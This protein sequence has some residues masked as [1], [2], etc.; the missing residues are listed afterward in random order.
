MS[1]LLA[2]P[3]AIPDADERERALDIARSFIVEAPAGSGKT[4]LLIQ[5]LLKLLASE[6]IADPG[7]I[8]AITFTRK[9]THE[10][11][12]RV[13]SQLRAAASG[14]EPA[15]PFD[16]ATRPLAEAALA[17][18]RQLGWDLLAHPNR[19][20]ISTIDALCAEIARSLPVLS[21]SGGQSP[22]EDASEL[23]QQ[24]ARQT[25]GL[26]GGD[27]RA[28]HRALEL[29]LLHRD[30]DLG[31]CEA[32]IAAMLQWRD[33]W[34]NLIPIA[35]EQLTDEYLETVTR[36][37]L[38]KA[39][40]QAICRALTRLDRLMPPALRHEL[41]DLARRMAQSEGYQGTESPIAL[42]RELHT[43]PGAAAHDLDH[44]RSLAHVAIAP[45]TGTFRK[46]AGITGR[47]LK[48]EIEKRHKAELVD[49]LPSLET[50]PGLRE[51]L[52]D[53]ANLPPLRY[54]DEQWVVA[55]ALFRVLSRALVE[56]QLVFAERGACDFTEFAILARS[57]LD[58]TCAVDD[59]TASIGFRLE[60]L[61][62]DEMQD[63]SNSQYE[64]IRLLTQ[65][66]DGSG[67]TV[68]LVGDPKQS[69]YLFRQAR[70]ER[71][72]TTL[73]TARLGDVPLTPLRLTANFRSQANLV[74]SFN[75]TFSAMF[76]PSNGRSIEYLPAHA[77][78]KRTVGPDLVWHTDPLPYAPE[79]K[80]ALRHDRNRRNSAHIADIVASWRSRPL[81]ANRAKPWRIAVLVRNHKHLIEVVKAFQQAAIPFRAVD[82]EPLAERPEILDLLAL[83]RALLNPADRTAWLALLR[84]PW[85][86]VTLRDLHLL[87][88]ADSPATAETPML[89]LIAE[90]GDLLSDDGV[91]RLQPFYTAM[92]AA[93]AERGRQPLA[94]WVL[95]T[96]E[97][98]GARA[99]ST[100]EELANVERFLTLL[101]ELASRPEPV[102]IARLQRRV[103]R[104]YA[105]EST[106]LNAVD[107][108]TMHKAKGLEWDVVLVPELEASSARSTGRLLS[109][110]EIESETGDPDAAR[111]IIA[112]V[113]ARGTDSQALNRWMRSID[114]AREAEERKRLFYVACTRAREEL[115]LFAAPARNAKGE[116]AAAS[117]SLLNAAWPAAQPLFEQFEEYDAEPGV[118]DLAAGLELVP[119]PPPRTVQRIPL[120]A[121]PPATTVGTPGLDS[122]TWDR[123]R[124][125]ILRTEGSFEARAFG[126]AVHTFLESLAERLAAGATAR[127]L[128]AELPTWTPRI[129]ALLRSGGLAPS[130]TTRG[131]VNVLRVLTR[132]LENPDGLW[133]L[134]PHE[135]AQSESSLATGT[136][137]IRIDRTFLAGPEPRTTGST[138]LWIVDFKTAAPTPTGL[139]EFLLEERVRHAPQLDT[140]ATHLA[141]RGLPI[142][143]ALYHPAVAALTWWPFAPTATSQPTS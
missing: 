49:L 141:Q 29:L 24:A 67:Q 26:L 57:A 115:H 97:A 22:V 16:A 75:E 91:E 10:M 74:H 124:Q 77:I 120:S 114:S 92:V 33:Q 21:G 109:W 35:G 128:V 143:L 65:H 23:Y 88:G 93:L 140:Y 30:G 122:E 104:L 90:R 43:A 107:L 12:D 95:R 111:G 94:Q 106:A 86:G 38:E 42:C 132:T 130:E 102:T 116:I 73:A 101:D 135:G 87:A 129:A 137:E 55:K 134:S 84:S 4:G 98:F 139:E 15:N 2:F 133:L 28:L 71:F 6:S 17:R 20:N 27:D 40:E 8:L 44:W 142:R 127:Q 1:N 19:L 80:S 89:D 110:L 51:A 56:L 32:L 125:T 138:H 18:D 31:N 3:P 121:I 48:F 96:W 76:P 119:P 58:Q 61:L 85:C 64:L 72:L 78:R 68:F 45:S 59:L 69:I 11:R 131:A 14:E 66:W 117:D 136:A 13:L 50:T 60:H 53:L 103:D 36:P 112:P 105:A 34:A 100:P 63:T 79:I 7:Q 9:A 37:L 41:A 82:T 118:L 62:V 54:P 108:M 83:T 47:N 99:C 113:Q 70:V 81:P 46:P 25:L 123:P 126:T 5:R 52:C 39:L